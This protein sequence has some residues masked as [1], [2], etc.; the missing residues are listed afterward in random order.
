MTLTVTYPTWTEPEG[1]LEHENAVA[2]STY[3]TALADHPAKTKKWAADDDWERHRPIITRMY[4]R[5]N[6]KLWQIVDVMSREHGFYATPKMYKTRFKRWGLW[7]NTKAA[8]V[9]EVLRQ[10]DTTGQQQKLYLVN[11]KQVDVQ[12]V[13]RY[14]RNRCRQFR[15][16]PGELSAALA[17]SRSAGSRTP[18]PATLGLGATGMLI[19][20]E[21]TYRVVQDYF[22][23]S[24]S[25]GR[26]RFS[27]DADCDLGTDGGG[28]M[29]RIVSQFHERF[30]TAVPLLSAPEDKR[31]VEGVKMARIC[32][33]ELPLVLN[34]NFGPEDPKLLVLFLIVL[35]YIRRAGDK[36]RFIEVQLVK[37]MADLA[38]TLPGGRPTAAVWAMLRD[39]VVNGTMNDHLSLQVSKVATEQCRRHLGPLHAKTIELAIVGECNFEYNIQAQEIMFKEM[40]AS[41][42]TFDERLAGLHMNLVSFYC[43]HK[44]DEKCVAAATEVLSDPIRANELRRWRGV[45]Y[46][47]HCELASAQ[48]R[49]G[50]TAD[51]ELAFRDALEVAKLEMLDGF[52]GYADILDGLIH[53]ERCLRIQG[54]VTEAEE[55]LAEREGFIK[56]SLEDLGE[57]EEMA[58]TPFFS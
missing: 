6:K 15:L 29:S 16:R 37:Y 40:M 28:E 13:D 23:G 22:D 45:K 17:A 18:S 47:L 49:L 50:N 19:M 20:E 55:A 52:G 2:V 9:A 30:K 38:Q 56:E 41:L 26:W 3:S 24:L 34:S 14:I 42:D 8:D 44:M 4:V 7:K 1:I 54:K 58:E 35:Q 46:K 11:G 51:A 27:S 39:S 57:Q 32:F 53:L 10:R 36:L 12:R 25:S 31:G 21:Y 33:A 48:E 43:L 5:E